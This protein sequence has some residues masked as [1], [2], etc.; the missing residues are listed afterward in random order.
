L[1][2]VTLLLISDM[3]LLVIPFAFVKYRNFLVKDHCKLFSSVLVSIRESVRC[4]LEVPNVLTSTLH[5]VLLLVCSSHVVCVALA[6][7]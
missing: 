6:T 4:V 5:S 3:T 1:Y 7:L 2:R